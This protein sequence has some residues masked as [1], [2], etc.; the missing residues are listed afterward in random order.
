MSI[1]GLWWGYFARSIVAVIVAHY[2]IWYATDWE[3]RAQL[4]RE[5]VAELKR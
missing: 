1:E 5:N 4:L 3:G 2:I